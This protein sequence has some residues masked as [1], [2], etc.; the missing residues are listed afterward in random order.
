LENYSLFV[1]FFPHLLAGPIVHHSQVM[2]QFGK[3]RNHAVDPGH[4]FLGAFYFLA[5]LFQKVVIA[6]FFGPIANAGFAN[7]AL[8]TP[9]EAWGAVFAYALQIYFDFAGY[10]NM[11][12]GLALFFNIRFPVNF[13]SPYQ[14]ASIIDF[15]KRWHITLSN[16]LRQYLYFPLGGNRGGEVR[17]YRNILLTMLLG[18][19]WHGAGWTF[20]LWGLYHGCLIVLNHVLR[21][22]RAAWPKI[23]SV[24]ATF[25]LVCYGWVLFRSAGLAGTFSM[26]RALFG[27]RA[28]QWRALPFLR[29]YQ[30][31]A[32]GAGLLLVFLFPNIEAWAKKIRP[33]ARWFAVFAALWAADV[34]FLNRAS[35][36]LYFQF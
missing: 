15:W 18:G 6:D 22:F 7:S 26:T 19:L 21:R 20:V 32:I 4:L 29:F 9:V 8:L 16:F 35:A 17:R 11:A 23:I 36:F 13:N 33:D 25:L 12:I 28:L 5:G 27:A 2:P 24:P 34:L 1:S 30:L 31:A 3:T 14:A 10:S